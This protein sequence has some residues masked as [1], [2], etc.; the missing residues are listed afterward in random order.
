MNITAL[1]DTFD[2]LM[3]AC[4]GFSKQIQSGQ[5]TLWV[6]LSDQEQALGM[7]SQ[8][9]AGQVFE[10][11]W[12]QDGQDGRETR[13]SFGLIAA[14]DALIEA[15]LNINQ[16]KD[17]LKS[18][19]NH[20][21]KQ[22]KAQW[23]ELKGELN[24]RR[25]ELRES[26]HFSGLARL[27]LKQTWR[28]IPVI[29]RCPTRVGFNWY[30]SG[31]SIQ[32][33]SLEQAQKALEKMDISSPHIQTQLSALGQLR[34]GTP[35]AKVQNLAPVMRA[36]VFFD[37]NMTPDRLAMNVSLP[38][39]FKAGQDG[40]LPEHNTPPLTPPTERQRAVRS[41]RRIEDDPFLPS[42]RAHRYVT[43]ETE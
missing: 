14:D 24:I 28:H 33:L 10:D 38:L 26:L 12:Y 8:T 43:A 7:T 25:R 21:Q 2:E 1:V 18:L 29:E 11:V 9:K 40:K 19:A 35:L 37:D 20:M 16:L 41:D 3:D 13:S 27:H 17:S 5:Y 30:N 4:H 34:P 36:N 31:R 39:L 22:D 15:A 32:K 6:P 23:R 42:I